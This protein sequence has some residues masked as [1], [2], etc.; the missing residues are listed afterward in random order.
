MQTAIHILTP[1]V[2]VVGGAAVVVVTGSQGTAVVVVTGSQ[3]TAVSAWK[4]HRNGITFLQ[5]GLSTNPTETTISSWRER[6]I[7]HFC[8]FHV[9]IRLTSMII[10]GL[11]RGLNGI[12]A[13][14]FGWNIPSQS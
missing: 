13:G 5:E 10:F 7:M 8:S 4:F 1:M 2:V 14:I 6:I 11:G 3:G 9:I 12:F